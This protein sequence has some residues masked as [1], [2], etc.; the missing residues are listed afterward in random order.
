MQAIEPVR[1][2]VCEP[3]TTLTY[4]C[5]QCATSPLHAMQ[6]TI[7]IILLLIL[8]IIPQLPEII[9][10]ALLPLFLHLARGVNAHVVLRLASISMLLPIQSRIGRFPEVEQIEDLVCFH[11]AEPRVLLVDYRAGDVDFESLETFQPQR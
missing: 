5:D 6:E 8:P 9:Q 7:E 4:P 2:Y 1:V 11:G 10:Q 3:L